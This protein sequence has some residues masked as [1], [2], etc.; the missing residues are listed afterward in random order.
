MEK[1]GKN[2]WD[3]VYETKTSGQLSWTQ[4]IPQTSLD[5]I[6]SFGLPMTAKIIDIGGGDSRLVDFLLQVGFENITVLDISG[7]AL[8]KAK[9]R[10]GDSAQK[11]N[12]IV[13]DITE[14]QPDTMYD[15]WHDRATFHFLTSE[16]RIKKYVQ[17][18]GSHIAA[19]GYLVLA[20]FSEQG[21]QKCSGLEIRQ[22]SQTT[23]SSRFENMFE[24]IK[25]LDENHITPAKPSQQF[26]FCSFRKLESI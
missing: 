22:Y 11:V 13:S 1:T 19:G 14:F 9:T 5:F 20:T 10:L 7:K 2:H 12:W 23:M 21:P 6:H 17:V 16:E 8:E 26:L 15:L 3:T 18:C 24:R 4:E 25:C